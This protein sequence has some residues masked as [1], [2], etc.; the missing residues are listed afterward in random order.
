MRKLFLNPAVAVVT[1][2]V[3]VSAV[4]L[5]LLTQQSFFRT[6][7]VSAVFLSAAPASINA[8]PEKEKYA[9][10]SAVIKEMY[11]GQESKL[12]VVERDNYCQQTPEGEKVDE[13]I[14]DMR[15]QMEE[16]A[17]SRLPALKAETI[18]DFH[19]RAKEC[20]PLEG[21]F[22][23]PIKYQL[24]SSRDL[25]SLFHVGEIE[26]GWSRFYKKYPGS[27]GVISFSNVGFNSE[28]NQALVSTSRGCG[29]LCGAGYFVILAKEQGVWKVG[30]KIM[31]WVS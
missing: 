5:R 21:Q 11:L 31:T 15:R 3:G 16:D 10:Y 28:M 13:K 22:D 25:D 18:N 6:T 1:F 9:V 27:S 30:S 4:A 12:L 19:A 14:E 2:S 26:G 8:D 24:I 17:F 7:E 20:H 23:I 29:G